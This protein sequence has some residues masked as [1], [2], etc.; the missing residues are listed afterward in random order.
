MYLGQHVKYAVFLSDFNK[1]WIYST[2]FWKILKYQIT[3]KLV[4]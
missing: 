2:E 3:W 4:Q 1:T